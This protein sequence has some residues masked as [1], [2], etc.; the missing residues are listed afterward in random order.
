MLGQFMCGAAL[1]GPRLAI[2]AAHCSGGSAELRIGAQDGVS[3]G[4]PVRIQA[5][6]IHPNFNLADFGYDVVL[7][8][9]EESVD[10]PFIQLDPTEVTRDGTRLTVIGFGDTDA[11]F[12]VELSDS[13]LETE[14]EYINNRDCDEM[15]GDINDVTDD[16]LCAGPGRDNGDSCG[17]DSGGP[18]FLKGNSIEEDRLVGIVSW[19]RGCAN[20]NFPGGKRR[21]IP[22]SFC[23]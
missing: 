6:V 19:G 12:G 22:L 20:R 17:G 16:M 9:L 5:G 7:L 23:C 8:Y 1:I 4:Q 21:V 18:L 11:G 2:S 14:M 3:S 10:V 15:H 13:L